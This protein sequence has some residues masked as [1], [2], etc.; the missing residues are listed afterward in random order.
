MSATAVPIQP[1]KKGSVLKLWL[2]LILLAAV[3][4][5]VAWWG[6]GA[7]QYHTTSSGL[8]YR[9]VKE[10]EGAHPTP[11][12]LALIDYT[13]K[14]TSGKVFDSTRGKQPVPMSVSGTIPG[15]SEGLQ[16]MSKGAVYRFRIPP[17]LGY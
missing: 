4:V 10:G 7:M 17:Q 6:T 1:I 8:Q 3:A 5:A 13:G 15:F 16:L 14:L 9:V 12:D 11:A 2:A